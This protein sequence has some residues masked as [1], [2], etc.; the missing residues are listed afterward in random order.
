MAEGFQLFHVPQKITIEKLPLS[1]QTT[2]PSPP[3]QPSPSTTVP[4]DTVFNFHYNQLSLPSS[5][6]AT[7]S[8]NPPLYQLF[9][10]DTSNGIVSLSGDH[11]AV[12][13]AK[14]RSS[15][16]LGPFTGYAS[17]LR[18]SSFL[19]PAQQ[20][21]DDLCGSGH[22]VWDDPILDELSSP[23]KDPTCVSDRVGYQF[24]NSRLMFMLEE[25]RLLKIL[26]I[27]IIKVI[28]V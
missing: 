18:R 19:K 3:L 4:N 13:D 25:V 12:P 21:L 7:N 24:K 9:S 14:F 17:I 23:A 10:D 2:T 22:R 28:Y 6:H 20:L 8:S 16:P 1:I 11:F 5:H 26:I 27:P 15:V